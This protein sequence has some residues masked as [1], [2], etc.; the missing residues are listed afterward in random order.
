[1]LDLSCSK[2]EIDFCFEPGWSCRTASRK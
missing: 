1:L 2:K